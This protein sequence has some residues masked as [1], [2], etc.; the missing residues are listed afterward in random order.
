MA[1]GYEHVI[2]YSTGCLPSEVGVIEEIMRGVVF[3]SALDWQTREEL[4]Q[5]ARTAYAVFQEM[6][7]SVA[8]RNG[9]N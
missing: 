8:Q 3:H 6:N 7:R 4:E 5:G 1:T 2:L 9:P